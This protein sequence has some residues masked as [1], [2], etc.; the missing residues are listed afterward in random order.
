MVVGFVQVTP[1][2]GNKRQGQSN[3]LQQLVSTSV[4]VQSFELYDGTS[5]SAAGKSALKSLGI[6]DSIAK[7]QGSC[8][9]AETS[10][11]HCFVFNGRTMIKGGRVVKCAFRNGWSSCE[12]PIPKCA[13]I[14]SWCH[15]N[16]KKVDE[17]PAAAVQE[18]TQG[19]PDTQYDASTQH[20]GEQRDPVNAMNAQPE[21]TVSTTTSDTN[22]TLVQHASD[23]DGHHV[24]GRVEDQTVEANEQAVPAAS[25]DSLLLGPWLLSC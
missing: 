22:S 10:A 2:A 23:A 24:S 16:P 25:A 15:K 11:I 5:E 14:A 20:H 12:R 3:Q 18:P 19:T 1:P 17:Q 21:A 7:I 13:N 4:L 8:K 6:T 9:F